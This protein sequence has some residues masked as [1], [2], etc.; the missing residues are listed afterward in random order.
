MDTK[1]L[2][3]KKL[4]IILFIVIL[5]GLDLA[6]FI[7]KLSRL[8]GVAVL[9]LGL[10]LLLHI[11]AREEGVSIPV[12]LRRKLRGVLPA[13]QRLTGKPASGSG[14]V[15]AAVGKKEETKG[16]EE[17]NL[18]GR[19]MDLLTQG[20]M[21]YLF[22]VLGIFF[23]LVVPIYNIGLKGSYF[24]GSNDFVV[25]LVGVILLFYHRI[26]EDYRREKD[27]AVIF[28]VLLFLIV[29]LP[30]TYYQREYDSTEGSWEDSNP[31]SPLVESLLA[32]PVSR[33]VDLLGVDSF[34]HG[35]TI[36]Y[37]K[38]YDYKDEEPLSSYG[39]VSIALGCTGLYSVAIFLSGFIAFISVEY[40]RFDQ[41]VAI[42]LGLGILTS[43][44][45]NLLRMTI[46]VMVGS[47]YGYDALT[48]THE[49][50]GELLFLVWIAIFWSF[51]FRYLFDSEAD[52]A[53]PET[54]VKVIGLTGLVRK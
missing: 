14:M 41:K 27:F 38:N 37:E 7:S 20:Q 36:H 35:V 17:P 45:A 5:A 30:T 26:P 3:D 50:L 46:I 25:L 43:Y 22:P 48:W 53:G 49:N 21:R 47:H 39:E 32:R 40:K 51:M 1:L 24:L 54:E 6:I 44:V 9:A 4:K 8:I 52:K 34:N 12:Y 15:T 29:V 31:N 13:E 18:A 11:N 10:F 33:I 28:F 23:I 2:K 42:L 16:E 19:L